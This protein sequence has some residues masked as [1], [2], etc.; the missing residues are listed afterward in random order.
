M[1]K[2]KRKKHAPNKVV[3]YRFGLN[4]NQRQP[5]VPRL[6]AVNEL[7]RAGYK[8]LGLALATAGFTIILPV[9]GTHFAPWDLELFSTK[10]PVPYGLYWEGIVASLRLTAPWD[11]ACGPIGMLSHMIEF[12]LFRFE[13]FSHHLTNLWLHCFNIALL[14]AIARRLAKSAWVAGIACIFFAL[15]PIQIDTVAWVSQ[16]R[17]LLTTFFVLCA[18]YAVLRFENDRSRKWG[19]ACFASY[20]LAVLTYP[21]ALPCGLILWMTIRQRTELQPSFSTR[22]PAYFGI[23]I[24]VLFFGI[25]MLLSASGS[26]TPDPLSTIG[27]A[28]QSALKTLWD[29]IAFQSRSPASDTGPVIYGWAA[30]LPMIGIGLILYMACRIKA[31]ANSLIF[32]GIVWFLSTALIGVTLQRPDAFVPIYWNYFALAGLAV[33]LAALCRLVLRRI[34]KGWLMTALF[35]ITLLG[36]AFAASKEVAINAD[37]KEAFARLF[38]GQPN[39]QEGW[40]TFQYLAIR[41]NDEHRQSEAITA[42]RRALTFRYDPRTLLQLGVVEKQL[43]HPTKARLYFTDA[44]KTT[45]YRADAHYL[46][47]ELAQESGNLAEASRLYALAVSED[48]RNAEAMISLAMIKAAAP[49]SELRDAREG[50]RLANRALRVTGNQNLRAVSSLAACHA[51][52]GNFSKATVFAKTALFW[53]TRLSGAGSEVPFCKERYQCYKENKIWRIPKPPKTPIPT[54]TVTAKS[55]IDHLQKENA[56]DKAQAEPGK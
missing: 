12:R 22:K 53:S 30:I 24:L 13:P 41:L 48:D 6:F 25:E 15:I 11:A 3:K 47:G 40:R 52:L 20:I 32:F 51:E 54:E 19:I 10:S 55:G 36:T 43:G 33:S 28:S 23:A 7:W 8:W 17:I 39:R 14:F 44:S 42:F 45:N 50:L 26:A 21:I 5:S 18:F 38:R 31:F 34:G 49:E 16:R 56:L 9:C 46:L 4:Y 2:T 27:I 29:V 35:V 37:P 1:E